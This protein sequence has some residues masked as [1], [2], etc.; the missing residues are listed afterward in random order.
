M[1]YIRSNSRRRPARRGFRGGFHGPVDT[2]VYKDPAMQAEY[3]ARLAR[4]TTTVAPTIVP[5]TPVLTP[6]PAW[7]P[8]PVIVPYVPLTPPITPPISYEPVAVPMQVIEPTTR[9]LYP[10]SGSVITQV[11]TVQPT[12][13]EQALE[14]ALAERRI[15]ATVLP[16]G[17]ITV[18]ASMLPSPEPTAPIEMRTDYTRD[19]I[20]AA[21]MPP[22]EAPIPTGQSS[23][24][25]APM[26]TTAIVVGMTASRY[27]STDTPPTPAPVPSGQ[28]VYG[29]TPVP[30]ESFVREP[31]P[32]PAPL[33]MTRVAP[34]DPMLLQPPTGA[35]VVV[36][37]QALPVPPP[38]GG[39]TAQ[40]DPPVSREALRAACDAV[41]Y[42]DPVRQAEYEREAVLAT[43]RAAAVAS[44][45]AVQQPVRE[46]WPDQEYT[47][48]NSVYDDGQLYTWPDGSVHPYPLMVDSMPP[49]VPQP[50]QPPAGSKWWL[51]VALGVGA[52][53]LLKK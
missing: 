38:S 42:K 25:P 19:P 10:P 52:Y 37:D 47:D 8:Q 28:S 31:A 11:D 5:L 53:L 48:P 22:P 50:V 34:L 9:P 26:P 36:L 1:S 2:V 24:G 17:P 39:I 13:Q 23:Y 14:T 20:I 41:V 49:V 45:A 3:E 35:Q 51:W 43:A 12:I 4:R 46:A 18:P 32:A 21:A 27:E 29:P 33:V 7:E 6:M 30:Q 44:E 15:A 16:A 40:V